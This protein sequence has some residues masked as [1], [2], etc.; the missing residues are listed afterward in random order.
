[1][2]YRKDSGRGVRPGSLAPQAGPEGNGQ[3]I[4]S[5]PPRRHGSRGTLGDACR[6]AG[7]GNVLRL[8]PRLGPR[9]GARA[10]RRVRLR[11]ARLV[12]ARHRRPL[13]PRHRPRPGSGEAGAR[14]AGRRLQVGRRRLA[15]AVHGARRSR[16]DAQAAGRRT[17][18][19]ARAEAQAR[20]LRQGVP[21]P[22]RLLAGCVAADPRRPRVPRLAARDWR[23][24]GARREQR[25]PRAVP[26]GR[27]PERDARH[28]AGRGA[29]VAGDRRPHLRAH[30]P[31]GR[32]WRLR[33]PSPPPSAA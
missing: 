12:G 25:R 2:R 8:R 26:V 19:R 10:V 22:A 28:V 4:R 15:L 9:R 20:S 3:H 33:R 27:R 7:G 17:A 11:A 16:K 18:A 21:R 1:V 32:R 29:Q 30:P 6:A 14:A 5:S 24:D 13:L 31:P 23:Q